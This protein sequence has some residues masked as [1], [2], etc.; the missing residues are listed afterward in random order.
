LKSQK[1]KPRELECLTGE[2]HTEKG[3][4]G[5]RGKEERGG[6]LVKK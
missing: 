3:N 6:G 2:E 1:T 5:G 4:E